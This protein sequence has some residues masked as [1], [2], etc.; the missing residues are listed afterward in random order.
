MTTKEEHTAAF[1][2]EAAAS[3]AGWKKTAGGEVEEWIR[4]AAELRGKVIGGPGGEQ[5]GPGYWLFTV[6]DVTGKH[7]QHVMRGESSRRGWAM[8]GA[9][10]HFPTLS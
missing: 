1:D 9:D 8:D 10:S 6:V 3:R 5:P 7:E 4:E 2:Q